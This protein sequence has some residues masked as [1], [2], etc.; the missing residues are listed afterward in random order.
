MVG[1]QRWTNNERDENLRDNRAILLPL[2]SFFSP[3]FP[4]KGEEGGG[5]GG[6]SRGGKLKDE[7]LYILR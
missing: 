6:Q 2:S 5:G 1:A 7:T 3:P 4:P